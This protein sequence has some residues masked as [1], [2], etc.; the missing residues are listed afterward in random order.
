MRWSVS[1]WAEN[2][3]PVQAVQ[4]TARLII[5]VEK[6]INHEASQP[7]RLVLRRTDHGSLTCRRR[8]EF[9]AGIP[10][11]CRV[12]SVAS[13]AEQAE[14]SESAEGKSRRFGDEIEIVVDGGDRRI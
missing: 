7:S 10:S 4:K 1:A 2:C 9:G 14:G 13:P 6:P 11:G 12:E 3:L 5:F 8:V